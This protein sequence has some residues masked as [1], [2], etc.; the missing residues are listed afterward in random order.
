MSAPHGI[1]LIPAALA[2]LAALTLNVPAA[3]GQATGVAEA[4]SDK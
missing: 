1:A 2:A 4:G 3:L